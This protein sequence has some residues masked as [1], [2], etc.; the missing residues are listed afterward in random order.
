MK[1]K[2]EIVSDSSSSSKKESE[3]EMGVKEQEITLSNED[4]SAEHDS[5][6]PPYHPLLGPCSPEGCS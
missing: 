1:G 2:E 6:P 4:H 3:Y 5:R